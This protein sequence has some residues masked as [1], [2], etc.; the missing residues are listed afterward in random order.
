MALLVLM[1]MYST[2]KVCLP[3][4]HVGPSFEVCVNRMIIKRP[5]LLVGRVRISRFSSSSLF[6]YSYLGFL[7]ALG[8]AAPSNGNSN[9]WSATPSRAG[10]HHFGR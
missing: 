9:L 7:S 3:D 10:C 5:P 4:Y 8:R 1:A 2:W 6:V